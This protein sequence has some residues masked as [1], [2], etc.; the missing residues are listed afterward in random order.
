MVRPS[1]NETK[2]IMATNISRANF[3]RRWCG[4]RSMMAV[5]KPSTHPNCKGQIESKLDNR[6][7]MWEKT[8]EGKSNNM[9]IIMVTGKIFLKHQSI[10]M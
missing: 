8:V 4:Y 1:K 2:H 7:L 10:F 5:T 9:V 6:P 3:R